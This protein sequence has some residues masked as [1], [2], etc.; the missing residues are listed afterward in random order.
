MEIYLNSEQLEKLK[1]DN[2]VMVI[3]DLTSIKVFVKLEEDAEKNRRLG[4][5][6]FGEIITFKPEIIKFLGILDTAFVEGVTLSSYTFDTFKSKKETYTPVFLLNESNKETFESIRNIIES[7]FWARD[8][9]N[10]PYSHLN[11]LDF[12]AQIQNRFENT[13]VT[14]TFWNKQK[15]EEEKFGG[16]LAVNKAS[17]VEPRFGILEYKPNNPSNSRPIVLVGKGVVYD[18]GGLSLKPTENSMDFMKCDMAGLAAMVG[19]LD[20][21]QKNNSNKWIIV[22]CPITDNLIGNNALA[23]GD[24]IT[25]KSGHTVEVMDTDAEGRLIL[26]DALEFAKT[27]N[28]Q[29]VIDAA[30]LTGSAVRAIGDH[31]AVIMGN[32]P[33]VIF[34]SIAK[35]G[36]QTG[37]R[38]A[39]F[40]FWDDY[41]DQLK[42]EVADLKNLGGPTAGAITA[43]K[44]LANFVAYDWLHVDIAGPA[45]THK[46]W[47]YQKIG[48]TGFG[49]R[50]LHSLIQEL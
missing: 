13:P 40:P 34:H 37:E 19:T 6:V 26:A 38:V 5:K 9:V 25:M 35:I 14:T 33:S 8:L 46:P 36:E 10:L 45:Y 16:L 11:A 43:G 32:A 4:A 12:E 44:F 15:L 41:Q 29:I 48:G 22:L 27:L 24:V 17:S 49:V 47:H 1:P 20:A 21:L 39:R 23:P 28:P 2:S 30:T 18:T 31:A 3:N 42:S 7:V 50:L